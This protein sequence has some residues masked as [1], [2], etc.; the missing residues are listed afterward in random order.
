VFDQRL[1]GNG[2][3][4]PAGPLR[5]PM[6]RAR[7]ATL[8]N[9]PN[10]PALSATSA[11]LI[12]TPAPA[13][14]TSYLRLEPDDAWQI[15]APSAR[16]ALPTFAGLRVVAAAGIGSPERFFAMLR[17]FGIS[18]Q[19]RPLP[20]HHHFEHNPFADEQADAILV[21]EKDA[22]KCAGWH[23]ARLWAVPVRGV[24]DPRLIA[25]VVEKVR[26]RSPA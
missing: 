18:P 1:G 4:L 8:I 7:D 26:G 3:L 11:P 14:H 10:A 19:T 21:T 20:D 9:D 15:E 24:L 2:F 12:G 25:L 6:R 23:D 5:E 22:V 13:A 17:R 16:R